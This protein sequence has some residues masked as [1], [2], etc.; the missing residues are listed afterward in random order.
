MENAEEENEDGFVSNK[1]VIAFTANVKGQNR[2]DCLNSTLLA[3]LAADKKYP[4]PKDFESWYKY[5]IDVLKKIGWI[6]QADQII[7]FNTDEQMFEMESAILDILG[8]AL[9]GN[10]LAVLTKTIEAI[11]GLAKGSGK[12]KVFEQNTHTLNKGSFQ[13]GIA[14]EENDQVALTFGGFNL[15]TDTNIT[16]ILF[17]KSSKDE[18]RLKYVSNT[19]VLNA[20]VYATIRQKV[21]QKLGGQI[22]EVLTD[23]DI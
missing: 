16:Q 19:C 23:L 4:D 2:Q 20:Q 8:T 7:E 3:Q 12:L 5:Y 18:S 10:Q 17:F 9:T 11:K 14:S 13:I 1:S 15:A 22:E 6:I 21:L